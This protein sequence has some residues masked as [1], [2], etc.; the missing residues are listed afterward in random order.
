MQQFPDT[1]LHSLR[2]SSF[3]EKIIIL[4]KFKFECKFKVS[5]IAT[6]LYGNRKNIAKNVRKTQQKE[7]QIIGEEREEEYCRRNEG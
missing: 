4:Q 1:T 5:I 3:D 6:N 2:V 7:R